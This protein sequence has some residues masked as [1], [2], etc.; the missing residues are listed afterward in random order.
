VSKPLEGLLVVALEQAVAAPYCSGR[1]ADA[2]ARVI[3]IERPE[4]DFARHYDY[5][6][7]GESAYFSWLNKGKESLV[8]NIK[9]PED[10]ALLERIL[11]KADV[12]IQNLAP[13]AAKRAG[14]GSDELR[15][16]Y[17]SLITCDI[18]GYGEDNDASKM[19][20]YDLLV[21]AE[22]G[23][24]SLTGTEEAEGRVGVSVCDI[25]AGMNAY[26]SV[27]EAIIQRGVT[28]KGSG[29]AVSLFDGMADWM[30]VP[31]MHYEY[32]GKAPKRVGLRH[33]SIAPYGAFET[34]DDV[35]V[36][37]SIQNEREWARFADQILGQ[38]DWADEGPY[39]DAVNRVENRPE[40]DAFVQQVFSK[41][42]ADEICNKLYKADIAYGRVNEVSGLSDH[43]AL[44]KITIDSPSG[45]IT[46]PAP[47]A[48]VK[49][50]ERQYGAIPSIGNH[51]DALRKEFAKNG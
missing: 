21:Q 20:A 36:V 13:N 30:A 19:K 39:A 10:A 8:L 22:T 11:A 45:P 18:S 6:V 29:L 26:Q 7:H 2:G 47:P 27:L 5:V 31:L 40:L 46:M 12:Y 24:C 49:G 9:D 50:E 17:P 23:L 42:T 14:F 44:R 32:G 25:A 33:P 16:R 51:S 4:G 48:L 41:Q 38:P 34:A 37:V 15:E 28:G 1:L 43:A 3:K 35:K